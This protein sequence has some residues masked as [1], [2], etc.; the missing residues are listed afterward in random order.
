MRWFLT[1]DALICYLLSFLVAHYTDN[2]W[3]MAAYLVLSAG[4]YVLYSYWRDKKSNKPPE[5]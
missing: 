1:K 3:V 2:I 4:I 5:N